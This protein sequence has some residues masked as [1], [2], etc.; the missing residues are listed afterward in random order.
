MYFLSNVINIMSFLVFP[1]INV[2]FSM[3]IYFLCLLSSPKLSFE[4]LRFPRE[5]ASSPKVPCF[6]RE[7]TS[8]PKVLKPTSKFVIS[9]LSHRA[10]PVPW[11]Q[12]WLFRL[13][14]YPNSSRD[15]LNTFDLHNTKN[16]ESLYCVVPLM[17]I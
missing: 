13:L 15:G 1:K 11:V 7:N 5:S 10:T 2:K 6:L 9:V 17:F 4:Q 8:S 14:D 16:H 12:H 3:T